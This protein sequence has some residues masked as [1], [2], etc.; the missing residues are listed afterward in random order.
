MVDE[1]KFAPGDVL[2]LKSGGPEMTYKGDSMLG[3]AIC[4]W[5]EG[6]K[7]IEDTFPHGMLKK[8]QAPPRRTHFPS[9]M[10]V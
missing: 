1:A 3:D 2:Q 5:F 8:Y 7:K 6:A 10:V 9:A 4:V